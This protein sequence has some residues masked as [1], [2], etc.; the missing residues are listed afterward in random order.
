MAVV[1]GTCT[2]LT[3]TAQT[4]AK[5]GAAAMVAYAAAGH[6]CAGTI[7]GSVAAAHAAG[8]AV[9]RQGSPRPARRAGRARHAHVA[10]VH[11]R[12]GALLGRRRPERRHRAW[13]R[14]VRRGPGRALPR[15]GQHQCRRPAGGRGARRLDPRAGRRGQHRAEPGRSLPDDRDPLRLHR[16]RVG[17]HRRD[18]GRRVRRRVRPALRAAPHLRRWQ[19]DPRH[20]VRRP[21]RLPRL[22]AGLGHQRELRL[23]RGRATTSTCRWAR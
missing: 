14:Q 22:P 6:E 17:A 7:D 3:G 20:L 13:H 11:V 19:H 1:S 15:H 4:L 5:A 10:G 16:S 18:P 8:Q 23:R 9:G 2:D 12:P 21:D